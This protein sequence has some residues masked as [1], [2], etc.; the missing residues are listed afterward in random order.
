MIT[1]TFLGQIAGLNDMTGGKV[2]AHWSSSYRLKKEQ[3]EFFQWS[4]KKSLVV[5]PTKWPA[6]AVITYYEPDR[7]RD[8]DNVTGAG[9][10]IILDALVELKALPNDSRKYIRKLTQDVLVDKG[11]PRIEIIIKEIEK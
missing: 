2:R 6:E 5:T 9:A 11:N 8:V 7:R 4:V 1:C 10:K 3:V